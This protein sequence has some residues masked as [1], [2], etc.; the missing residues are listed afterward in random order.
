MDYNIKN[1]DIAKTPLIKS[2]LI[3][4][5]KATYEEAVE[6]SDNIL[7]QEL[8]WLIKNNQ[9]EQLF[10]AEYILSELKQ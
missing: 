1:I 7:K 9:L 2:L 10:L 4:Y 6:I 5:V 3:T 8:N